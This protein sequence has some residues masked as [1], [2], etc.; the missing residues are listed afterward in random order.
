MWLFARTVRRCSLCCMAER[1]VRTEARSHLFLQL[2]AGIAGSSPLLLGRNISLALG[3][4]QEGFVLPIFK[5][6]SFGFSCGCVL[7]RL[8]WPVV[9]VLGERKWKHGC[10]EHLLFFVSYPVFFIRVSSTQLFCTSL[11]L[12]ISQCF[13]N[14]AKGH[15]KSEIS[16]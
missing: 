11:A 12:I 9:S 4:G 7:Q 13:F 6:N 16:S 2:T 10:I 15:K 14:G 3:K 1:A 5:T 8:F